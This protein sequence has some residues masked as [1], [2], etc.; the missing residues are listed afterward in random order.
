[1]STYSAMSG[2]LSVVRFR[3]AL[4]CVTHWP[5]WTGCSREEGASCYSP[6][7][8]S[9]HLE[10]QNPNVCQRWREGNCCDW[11]VAKPSGPTRVARGPACRASASWVRWSG[12]GSP[13]L[14][15]DSP[16]GVVCLCAVPF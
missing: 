5:F 7:V 9:L 8:S 13:C 6:Q 4:A 16:S 1:V 14:L 10:N 11:A 15:L 2:R 3:G 12:L